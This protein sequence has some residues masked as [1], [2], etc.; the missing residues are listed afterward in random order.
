ML[1]LPFGINA[2]ILTDPAITGDRSTDAEGTFSAV[3]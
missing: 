3:V 2:N 1:R